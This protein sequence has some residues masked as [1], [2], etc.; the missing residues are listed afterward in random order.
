ME[1]VSVLERK[2][3]ILDQAIS[4]LMNLGF[5]SSEIDAHSRELE[6]AAQAGADLSTLVKMGL[7]LLRKER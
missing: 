6:Q 2:S 1:T 3:G 7:S 5:R 4:A